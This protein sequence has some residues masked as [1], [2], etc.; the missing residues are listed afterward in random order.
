MVCGTSMK[1]PVS[2]R[3][4]VLKVSI[5]R[6]GLGGQ[7]LFIQCPNRQSAFQKGASLR[8]GAWLDLVVFLIQKRTTT[9]K[10]SQSVDLQLLVVAVV[11]LKWVKNVQSDIQPFRH[12]D[13]QTSRSHRVDLRVACLL[14]SREA[15][16]HPSTNP[17][18]FRLSTCI[19]RLVLI[20]RVVHIHASYMYK[21]SNTNPSPDFPNS[22]L[23]FQLM[24][25]RA[26]CGFCWNCCC[27]YCNF[28]HNNQTIDQPSQREIWHFIIASISKLSFSRRCSS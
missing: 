24:P 13:R 18:T 22:W 20:E 23:R 27:C 15:P 1:S 12:W 17:I 2:G 9:P 19:V 7:K 6:G 25:G 14:P 21:H 4:K 5:G 16:T 26:L 3:K 28:K 10:K 11:E 8:K